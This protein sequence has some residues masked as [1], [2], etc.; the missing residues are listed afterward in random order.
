MN[1]WRRLWQR[2]RLERELDRE[3]GFHFE[4]L[5]DDHVRAGLSPEEAR[6]AAR[7]E[8]GGIAQVQEACRDA[9]RTR[10]AHDFGYDLRFA[11]RLLLK[12]RALTATA[13]LALAL[14]VGVNN[15]LFSIVN[16]LCI[17]GLPVH[18][19]DR[20]VF[21]DARDAAARSQP[22]T[23][24]ELEALRT[25]APSLPDLAAF[26]SAPVSLADD[27]H[28]ADRVVDAFVSAN[29]HSL[30]GRQ[31]VLGRDFRS[32]DDR[33]GAA[34]VVVLGGRV[35][36]TR[37]GGDPSI[38]GRTVR[39]NGSPATIVGVLPDDYRFPA[40][41]EIWQPLAAARAVAAKDTRARALGV[42]GRMRDGA[43][44][45]GV[46]GEVGAVDR[47]A[48]QLAPP[49]A[50][51]PALNVVP[52]NERFNGDITN[53]AW[54]A[55]TTVG[56]LIVLI[57][58]SNVANLLLARSVRR[59][60]EMAI[61]LSLGATRLRIVRQLLA[62]SLI[63]AVLGSAAALAFSAMALRLF[64]LAIPEGG[65]PFW[66]TLTMDGRVFAVLAAVCLGT[67]VVF[68][69]APALH[70]SKASVNDVLK[71][72]G[73]TVSRS[74]AAA[75]WTA[76]FLTA[77]FA[78]TVIL[79]AAVA[80][81]VRNYFRAERPPDVT[82]EQA[83]LVTTWITLPAERYRT[84]V[85][86]MA[87]YRSLQERLRASPSIASAAL[88]STVPLGRTDSR[89]VV[90]EG[91]PRTG[92]ETTRVPVVSVD[93]RYFE[94]LGVP[95]TRGRAFVDTDGSQGHEAAI[96]SRR[97]A[98][99]FFP[100]RD[101]L[102]R[103]I[104][105]S[106]EDTPS[107]NG[108]WLTIVGVVPML[109]G[110]TDP[111]PAPIVYL[112]FAQAAPAT[113]AIVARAAGDTSVVAA[114]LREELR[115]LDADLPLYR[116]MTLEQVNW[117]SGW[118]PRVSAGLIMTIACIALGLSTVGLCAMTAHAAA[119]RTREIGIRIALGAARWQVMMLVLRRALAQVAMGFTAGLAF[120]L[121]WV[122]FLGPDTMTSPANLMMVAGI[123][124]VVAMGACLWPAR[125]AAR[126]DP[127]T[128]LRSQ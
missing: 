98:E 123:L 64:A 63:L 17:R 30:M 53:P 110:G 16:A 104:R 5:V 73:A 46:R 20:M 106:V 85:E 56:V 113:A 109:E 96:V 122:R 97:F 99:L 75:R 31:P 54:I 42:F 61:R 78:L 26:T 100:E 25:G 89:H 76:G 87:L 101:P 90:V 115:A 51:R 45:G 103:R 60:R 68:G 70:V 81:S 34:A 52:I 120:T 80:S 88:A 59:S 66:V 22:L 93:P 112:P 79:L 83:R 92:A 6:R 117:E 35:W 77:E 28:A 14:G 105:L 128:V 74:R 126:L 49:D 114:R 50:K 1:W 102:G 65:L 107:G 24:D 36:K 23:L 4:R 69:L 67:V 29:V 44:L 58:C 19:P 72:S 18:R 37:Y 43:T 41:A 116:T 62:E 124:T 84:P 10:W 119:Q 91:R 2:D 15:T 86:G 108:R 9:R 11:A 48:A 47:Q 111:P 38:V 32:D 127:A 21:L 82:L 121:V 55:F 118:N 125:R 95:V 7:L 27:G 8:F 12:E 94:T 39:V 40:N 71:E 57:A 3:L 33:P 13:V